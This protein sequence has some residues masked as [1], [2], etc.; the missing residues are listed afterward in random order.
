MIVP[1]RFPSFKESIRAGVET[2][3]ALKSIL[4]KKG[5]STNVG[6]EGGFAPN[7]KTVEEALDTLLEAIEKAGYKGKIDLALDVA[8]SELW[9][10]EK[11]IYVFHKSDGS[12]KTSEEMAE[13]YAKQPAQAG[14]AERAITAA[15]RLY[16][17]NVFPAMKVTWGTYLSQMGH[18]Q[19]TGCFRCHTDEHKSRDGK[20]IRQD[21]ALCH[22]EM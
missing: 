3:H 14:D 11:K 9:D 8:A 6:D 15:E 17:T 21:C 10:K 2:F 18:S 20:L 5:M 22:K 16:R 13:F 7:L 19:M 1:K 4:K 12:K